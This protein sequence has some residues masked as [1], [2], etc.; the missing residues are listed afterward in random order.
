MHS[1]ETIDT[2]FQAGIE[3][4]IQYVEVWTPN[5]D[6][7]RLQLTSKQVVGSS[8]E[9]GH[10]TD[11]PEVQS[12]EGLPGRAW[13]L[14]SATILQEEPNELL[15][16]ISAAVGTELSALLAI[17]VFR[18]QEIRGVV[19][20]G[21]GQGFGGA[22]VWNRDER[23]ELAVQVSH[24]C[25][26][27]SFEF[28]SKY[29]RFPKGAGVPGRVWITGEAQM[30]KKLGQSDSFI[31]SF[32]ND[33]AIVS[34]VVGVPIGQ[35]R[36]FPDSVLLLLSS[37]QNPLAGDIELWNCR[38]ITA[39]DETALPVVSL[40]RAESVGG[41]LE[42]SDDMTTKFFPT[43]RGNLLEQLEMNGVPILSTSD[44]LDL[45]WGTTFNLAL[46]VFSKSELTGVL[47][48]M[49]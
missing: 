32:G 28:I 22:E 36:G 31:R 26:L 16:K 24:Y 7:S 37:A 29:T 46:P 5:K 11:V 33:P 18:Q 9:R 30:Q 15:K 19:V 13:H 4:M 14:K 39:T 6:A 42:E 40:V 27:P 35:S 17:P 3:T 20:L 12:G 21:L 10:L 47:N 41:S 49:F 25:G 38:T 8:A 43:W 23:D 44:E 48:L 45:P 1:A 34:T 2:S